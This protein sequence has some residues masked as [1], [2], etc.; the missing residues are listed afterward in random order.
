MAT[1]TATA[2]GTNS[3]SAWRTEQH[4]SVTDKGLSLFPLEKYDQLM[5]NSLRVDQL[6]YETVSTVESLAPTLSRLETAELNDLLFITQCITAVKSNCK[7]LKSTAVS[8]EWP[9]TTLVPGIM[10]DGL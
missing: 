9:P 5:N 6:A 4:S 1:V 2:P 10:A 7:E 3:G 8:T